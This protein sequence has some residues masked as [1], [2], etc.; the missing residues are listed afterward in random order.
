MTFNWLILKFYIKLRDFKL[1]FLK[2]LNII[3]RDFKY[4]LIASLIA[5]QVISELEEKG[6]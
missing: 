5:F 6:W 3:R 2:K 1:K 4:L